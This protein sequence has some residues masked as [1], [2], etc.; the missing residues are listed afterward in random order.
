MFKTT[1]RTL[2]VLMTI[3]FFMWG[4]ITCLN[5]ILVPHLKA[6]FNLNYAEALLIQF[7]FFMTYAI[8]SIPMSLLVSRLD[9]KRSIVC[10]LIICSLG[11]LLFIPAATERLYALFLFGLFVLASGIVILQVAANPCV[12]SLGEARTASSRLTLAQGINS[13]GYTIAP[14]LVG[15]IIIA[16]S[17]EMPYLFLVLV[18]WVLTLTIGLFQF[19]SFTHSQTLINEDVKQTGNIWQYPIVLLGAIAIFLYVGAE[20]ATGSLVVNYLGLSTIAAM[21]AHVAAKYLSVYW[22]GA[23]VG[24][25]LGSAVLT[26]ILPNR[27]IIF[28]ALMASLLIIISLLASGKISMWAILSLG[29]FN[30]I[31]F[32]TIFA[33][34]I[35]S[36][37]KF[38]Q[39]GAGILCTAI[40]GGALVPEIQGIIADH[41]GL[42]LSFFILIFC[43]LYI[44]YFGWKLD[45]K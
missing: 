19:P 13:L 3:L 39:Q 18:L 42:K 35:E 43:Y 17:V 38:K 33:L 45:R 27:A 11:C 8:M 15:T 28:N 21:P 24:R 30:S 29:I 16:Y 25:F 10:G 37:G 40:V 5:D 23:M 14:I 26:R 32:P 6:L 20:V 2:M 12:V 36:L 34:T 1:D 22:G 41:I 4:F 44:A 9:Y 7:C 31:M